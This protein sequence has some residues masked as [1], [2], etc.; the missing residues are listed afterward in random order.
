MKNKKLIMIL[1][2]VF[3]LAL[4]VGVG[5]YAAGAF[6]TQSDP[7]V[8]KSYLDDVL[9]P[10]LQQ[11]YQ[12]Q[13]DTQYKVLEDKISSMSSSLEGNFAVVSLSSGKT[14]KGSAGCEMILRSGSA[15][16]AGSGTLADVT[17]GS[18]LASGNAVTANHLYVA[19][20]DGDGVRAGSGA[21]SLLVRGTYSIS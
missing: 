21:V 19:G 7:L 18:M 5:A 16:S 9:A 10:K 3:I 2:A 15:V 4:G 12:S 20:T 6:G 14:L 13:L 8:A 1:A 11:Q 17:S